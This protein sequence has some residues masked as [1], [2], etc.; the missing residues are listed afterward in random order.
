MFGGQFLNARYENVSS[1]LMNL[2]VN[3]ESNDILSFHS[4]FKSKG[5]LFETPGILMTKALCG[6]CC[7]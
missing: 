6:A 2:A 7:N 5:V 4:Y 1:R 3:S